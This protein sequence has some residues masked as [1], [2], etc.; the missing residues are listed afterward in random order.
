MARGWVMAGDKAGCRTGRDGDRVAAQSVRRKG[1]SLAD[2]SHLRPFSLTVCLVTEKKQRLPCLVL[3]KNEV[4]GVLS[5][6]A[7]NKNICT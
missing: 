3:I 4:L 1:L 2:V 7:Q 5:Q 6:N